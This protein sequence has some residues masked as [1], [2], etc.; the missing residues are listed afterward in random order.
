MLGIMAGMVGLL[1]FDVVPRAVL[2]LLS[3]APDARH[4]GRHGPQDSVE[5][6]R[7]S[8]W[9]RF[10]TCPLLCYEWYL[11][12]DSAVHCL[13]FPQLQ[14]I[15]VVDF[16]LRCRGLFPWSCCSADHRVSPSCSGTCGRRPCY[17]GRAVSQWFAVLGHADD[18]P[19]VVN[20]RCLELDSVELQSFRS[21]SSSRSSTLPVDTQRQILMVLAV[22]MTIEVPQ[23]Q[24]I[25][26]VADVLV[27]HVVQ[28]PQVQ[29]V[30]LTC[31]SSSW[32]RSWT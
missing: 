12:S 6:H 26:N 8:S 1:V 7:C 30:F 28:V 23:L 9:T 5:V 27:V 29:V 21:C 19:V 13:A 2:L 24:L 20:N 4:H 22:Q 14:F 10:S 31:F 16:L 15:T 3:Q 11:G 17:A 25:D 32:C 18:M